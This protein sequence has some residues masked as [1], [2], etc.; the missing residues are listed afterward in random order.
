[1]LSLNVLFF[2]IALKQ[3]I[4]SNSMKT[5]KENEDAQLLHFEVVSFL[6][7]FLVEYSPALP[8]LCVRKSH[9]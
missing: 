5:L 4:C 8:G 6:F 2:S 1:M 9:M 3:N 7:S